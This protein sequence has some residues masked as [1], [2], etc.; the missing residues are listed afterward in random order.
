VN[1][2]PA[3]IVQNA[4][5][6]PVIQPITFALLVLTLLLA[7]RASIVPPLHAFSTDQAVP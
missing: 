2:K 4:G 1:L 5:Q 7:L 3:P 6:T